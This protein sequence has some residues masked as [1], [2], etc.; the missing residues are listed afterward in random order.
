LT[1]GVV[2]SSA[3]ASV[4][5]IGV[6]ATGEAM[7]EDWCDRLRDAPWDGGRWLLKAVTVSSCPPFRVHRVQRD[8]T[9]QG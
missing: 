4:L 7:L 8:V 1:P 2:V 9:C 6:A 5:T 3:I